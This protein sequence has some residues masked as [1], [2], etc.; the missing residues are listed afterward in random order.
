MTIK[1]YFSLLTE[2]KGRYDGFFLT[3][4]EYGFECFRLQHLPFC[5]VSVKGYKFWFVSFKALNSLSLEMHR[6]R[7]DP[8]NWAINWWNV[9]KMVELADP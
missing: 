2:E 6:H 7:V 9:G 1:Y 4:N 5:P 8:I 3:L